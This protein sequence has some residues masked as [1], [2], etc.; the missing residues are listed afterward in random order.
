MHRQL[1]KGHS[2]CSSSQKAALSGVA[3]VRTFLCILALRTQYTR[4][5][6]L[7]LDQFNLVSSKI[8]FNTL[9]STFVQGSLKEIIRDFPIP[10]WGEPQCLWGVH[11]SLMGEA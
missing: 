8:L 3:F 2:N 10:R 7:V 4:I 11:C 1:G 6:G 9:S 5:K